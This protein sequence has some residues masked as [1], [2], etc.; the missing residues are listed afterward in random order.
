MTHFLKA[1]AVAAS[2]AI[3]GGAFMACS[4]DDD[5]DDEP[6]RY[7]VTYETERGEKPATKT[8]DSGYALTDGDLPA[9]SAEGFDFCGWHEGSADGSLVASGYKVTKN[10]TL[11]AKWTQQEGVYTITYKNGDEVLTGLTPATYKS[12]DGTVTLPTPTKEHY[13]FGGWYESASDQSG[14]AVTSFESSDKENKIFYAKFTEI[15]HT[16]TLNIGTDESNVAFGANADTTKTVGEAT[17]W[18]LPSFTELGIADSWSDHVPYGWS[19]TKQTAVS[20][21]SDVEY[22]DNAKVT[23]TGDVTLYVLWKEGTAATYS[24]KYLF[25][26]VD[27]DEYEEN[28]SL[29]QTQTGLSAAVGDTITINSETADISVEGFTVQEV[30]ATISNKTGTEIEVKYTRNK[31]SVSYGAGEGVSDATGILS[32][33]TEVKYGATV[34]LATPTRTGYDFASW[35]TSDVLISDNS[36]TMPDKDVALTAQW[37]IKQF[38]VTLT[39][40]GITESSTTVDYNS[41]YSAPATPTRTGYTFSKWQKD[42]SDVSFPLT[43]TENVTLTATWEINKHKVAIATADNGTV[44][45]KNDTETITSNSTEIDYGTEL[46]IELTANEGYTGSVVVKKGDDEITVT[47]N[48]FTMPDSDVTVTATFSAKAAEYT[49]KHLFQKVSGGTGENDYEAK[50]GYADETMSGTVGEQTVAEAKEVEGFEAQTITQPK[51]EASGTVV[52]VK[53]NRKNISL[54]FELDG[55][56]T[57]TQLTENKLTGL[58]GANVE[59]AAPTKEGY[60][61][62]SWNQALPQTFP[63]SD[64]TY[65]AQYEEITLTVKTGETAITESYDWSAPTDGEDTL[66]LAAESLDGATVEWSVKTSDDGESELVQINEGV[67]SF[68]DN[69]TRPTD[70][71]VTVKVTAT[72]LKG[73]GSTSKEV[74]IVIKMAEASTGGG[75]GGND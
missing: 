55:G 11:V 10:L 28:E 62:T 48:K 33:T 70:D 47:D 54:T 12:S 35:T 42:N 58:Y 52:T 67:L 23:P 17:G 24:L 69:Q 44:T 30:S 29:K 74:S 59:I 31:H 32:N 3:L 56:T 71:D 40:E 61:F 16:V 18:Q 36:F 51:I 53:Y 39:G 73:N 6:V 5:E 14:T 60:A 8:V 72:A 46:T 43:I 63:A 75:S 66:T 25:E 19:T 15:T 64:A 38:A 1:V 68:K 20:A 45:V 26:K 7:T 4:D 34:T 13:T 37:Q 41:S 27:G 50:N 49:V 9:L 21:E 2:L 65:T 22:Q 57:T